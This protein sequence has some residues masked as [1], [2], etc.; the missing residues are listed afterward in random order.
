[1][2]KRNKKLI[3]GMV[4]AAMTMGIFT[5]CASKPAETSENE[6]NT[7][8]GE[9]VVNVYSAR[10]YD[11]DKELFKKFEEETGIKVNLVEGKTDE[12]IERMSREGENSSADV[13]LTVGAENISTLQEKNLIKETSSDVINENIP[14]VY[15]GENWVGLTSRARVIAYDK[16]RVNPEDIDSYDDLLDDEFKGKVLSRSSSSSYNVALLASFIQE[17]GEEEAMEWAKGIVN[18]FARTPEGNDRDQVKAIAAGIGDVAIVN[19][20]YL[21]KM[22]SSSDA[23]E[24]NAAQNIGL[25][26][27]EDT[28]INLSFA[29]ITSSAKNNENAIKLVEFLTSEEAQSAYAEENGEF[30]LNESVELPES[31]KEWGNFDAQDID[32]EKLGTFKQKAVLIFDQ[33]GWK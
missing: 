1:M 26:F 24:V 19:S 27:P 23:E 9:N 3:L 10:H 16:S 2:F 7:T 29:A 13:I 28:H 14:D 4:V 21:A 8:K 20:Y 30:P 6:G 15:R 17:N 22:I 33:I 18:N 11:V 31:L 32:F 5:G 25:I 12:L